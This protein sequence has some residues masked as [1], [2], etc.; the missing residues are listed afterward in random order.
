MKGTEEGRET[1][2]KL[3]AKSRQERRAAGTRVVAVKVGTNG[4]NLARI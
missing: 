3:L 4:Q 2:K 1:Y